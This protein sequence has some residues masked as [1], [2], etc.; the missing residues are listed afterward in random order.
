MHNALTVDL[1]HSKTPLLKAIYLLIVKVNCFP[2]QRK[3]C[4]E[5]L[6]RL[7]TRTWLILAGLCLQSCVTV[8]TS[9]GSHSNSFIAWLRTSAPIRPFLC[10]PVRK[11]NMKMVQYVLYGLINLTTI[12][13]LYWKYIN[14]SNWILISFQL[15]HCFHMDHN[16]PCLPSKI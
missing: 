14:I 13:T 8:L 2:D 7:H 15:I 5:T 1:R 9:S 12:Y 4:L 6:S 10:K 11:E 16:T 3:P